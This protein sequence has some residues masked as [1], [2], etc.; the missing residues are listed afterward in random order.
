VAVALIAFLLLRMAQKLQTAVRSPLSF[1]RLIK[2]NVMHPRRLDQLD[3]PPS[4]ALEC[5]GQGLL[6][7]P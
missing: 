5:P 7:L 3:R 2:L 6:C 4:K 1:A